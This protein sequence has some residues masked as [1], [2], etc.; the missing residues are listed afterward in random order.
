MVLQLGMLRPGDVLF[1]AKARIR[2]QVMADA[3]V[4][5]DGV[6]GSI[7]SVGAKAQGRAACNGWTFWHFEKP[8]AGLA[9]IDL[10]RAEVRRT[11]MPAA[12]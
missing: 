7:H 11:I 1:D 10:L 3:S 6:R 4:V 5:W 8:K 12:A 9:P 2:A